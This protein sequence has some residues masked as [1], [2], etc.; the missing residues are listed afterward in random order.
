MCGEVRDECC[1][2]GVSCLEKGQPESGLQHEKLSWPGDV[3]LYHPKPAI[4]LPVSGKSE[5]VL[6]TSFLELDALHT[7]NSHLI[8]NSDSS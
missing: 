3:L 7:D 1:V 8:V 6:R 4:L 2:R 5:M